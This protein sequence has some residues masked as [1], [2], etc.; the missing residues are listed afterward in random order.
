MLRIAAT[1][2]ERAS[3][4]TGTA[5][6]PEDRLPEDLVEQAVIDLSLGRN[7]EDNFQTLFFA[8]HDRLLGFFQRRG[9]PLE[10]AEDLVQESFI[11]MERAIGSFRGEAPF[12]SW[13]FGLAANVYRR[14]RRYRAA[15]K[16]NGREV[17]LEVMDHSTAESKPAPNLVSKG[18]SPLERTLEQEHDRKLRQAIA[19]LPTQMCQCALLHW[20]EG[21]ET[22]EVAKI[23]SLRPATV[24]VQLFRAKGRLKKVL[25]GSM[26]E[27]RFQAKGEA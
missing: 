13:F 25:Q 1:L 22:K 24:R 21:Y 3:D 16:R 23:L 5:A 10:E 27:E 9:L 26:I 7:R 12:N 8:Y 2:D 11:A 14:H 18:P 20:I 17:S 4:E 15:G 6:Q 19:Q